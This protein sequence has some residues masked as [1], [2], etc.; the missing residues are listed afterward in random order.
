MSSERTLRTL[1]FIL[2]YSAK[3]TRPEYIVNQANQDR[4]LLAFLVIE[5]PVS[6]EDMCSE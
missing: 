6:F 5:L 2:N 1:P 4:Y 3:N